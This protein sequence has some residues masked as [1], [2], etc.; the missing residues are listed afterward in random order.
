MT[1]E[2]TRRHVHA[3]TILWTGLAVLALSALLTIFDQPASATHEVC[4]PPGSYNCFSGYHPPT[5][6]YRPPNT[7]RPPTTRPPPTTSPPSRPTNPITQEDPTNHNDDGTCSPNCPPPGD[8]G[9]GGRPPTTS[10]PATQPPATQPPPLSRP[11]PGRPPLSR[12]STRPPVTR[13]P[14][15]QPGVTRPPSPGRPPLSRASPG[16][17]S[18]GRPPLSRASPGR[19]PLSRPPLSRPPLSRPPP[20]RPPSVVARG[21]IGI[22]AGRVTALASTT[23][24]L[25]LLGATTTTT[26]A[27]TTTTRATTTTTQD[28]RCAA[29]QHYDS[30]TA[31]CHW[32]HDLPTCSS[33]YENT[34]EVHD[35]SHSSGHITAVVT[36]CGTNTPLPPA[37]RHA[38]RVST[39]TASRTLVTSTTPTLRAIRAGLCPIWRISATATTI[40]G[41]SNTPVPSQ[42]LLRPQRPRPRPLRSQPLP[43]L[44]RR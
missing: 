33:S 1:A 39:I 25:R 15:T 19:P 8:L 31:A 28:P 11:S 20:V 37:R 21:G 5:T 4:E 12:A 17:P 27:T 18:P 35:P 16:R 13:P 44:R 34:Y 23:T 40:S 24:R 43:L 36:Q 42:P 6:Q 29:G 38:L 7:L 32:N 26:R 3:R 14:T 9:W 41:E 10:P 22:A 2:Q 30:Y